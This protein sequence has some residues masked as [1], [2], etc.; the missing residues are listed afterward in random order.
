MYRRQAGGTPIFPSEFLRQAL[1]VP[2]KLKFWDM[3][4][5]KAQ[6]KLKIMVF[7]PKFELENVPPW[8]WRYPIFPRD[9]LHQALIVPLKLKFGEHVFL[10]A[11]KK[12]KIKVFV[13]KFE[14]ENVPPWCWR[15]SDF[16]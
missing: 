11:Q 9:F 1:T 4:F 10:K 12:L 14:L 15:Y 13:P 6:K 5:L 3:V 16:S 7:L 8:S 2:F